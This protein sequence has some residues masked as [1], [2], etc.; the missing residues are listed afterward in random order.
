MIAALA[1][2]R[3]AKASD[4]RML[5]VLELELLDEVSMLDAHFI[6]PSLV[7]NC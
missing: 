1:R 3:N 2:A 6:V 5:S 7:P 4:A